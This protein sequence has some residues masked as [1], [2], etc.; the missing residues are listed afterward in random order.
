MFLQLPHTKFDVFRK[1]RKLVLE[2]YKITGTFPGDERFCLSQ[3]L[4]R[5]ALSAHLNVGEGF[6]RKSMNER[7]R[8]FEIS[9]GSVV[10]VDTGLDIA[11]ELNYCTPDNLINLEICIEDGFRQL[12]AL[13]NAASKTHP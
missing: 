5:A 3:Q 10:E 13:I 7:K 6:S 11:S 4:R 2:V 8:F 1:T 12:S 9:R